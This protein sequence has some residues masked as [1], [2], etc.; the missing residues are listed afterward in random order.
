MRLMLSKLK[1]YHYKINSGALAIKGI[2][3]FDFAQNF[4]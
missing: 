4:G 1:N 2:L 3:Y